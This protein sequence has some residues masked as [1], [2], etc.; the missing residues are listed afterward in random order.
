MQPPI[1]AWIYDA[2][3]PKAPARAQT[4]NAQSKSTKS[5]Y[6]LVHRSHH[7]VT[8]LKRLRVSRRAPSE[9]L[10]VQR[11]NFELATTSVIKLCLQASD[12]SLSPSTHSHARSSPSNC[13]QRS[14]FTGNFPAAEAPSVSTFQPGEEVS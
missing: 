12:L 5:Q 2:L 3:V 13:Y 7:T 4:P 10:R 6:L 9:K 14:E 11:L 8:T 1:L